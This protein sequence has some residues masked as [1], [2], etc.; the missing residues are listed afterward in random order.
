MRFAQLRLLLSRS[1]SRSY[2]PVIAV[3]AVISTSIVITLARLISKVVVSLVQHSGDVKKEI[4]CIC[5]IWLFRAFFQAQYEYF[6]SVQALKIKAQI[7]SQVT[8]ALPTFG[9]TSPAALTNLLVKGFNSLDIY[10]G[11]FFPQI[12]SALITPLAVIAVIA[13][14]DPTSALIAIITLPL[15]PFFG[16]LIG[17]YT[18]DSV[19]KKWATLGTLSKYFED[20][21]RGFVTL[22]IFGRHKSQAK[23]IREMGDQYTKETMQVLRISFL[24]AFALELCATLSVALIAVAIGL[25]LVNGDISFLSGLTVLLLAPEVYFPLR[26]AAALFHASADG[27]AALDE[28]GKL[29][30]RASRQVMQEANDFSTFEEISWSEWTIDI[31]TVAKSILPA[32]KVKRGEVLFITGESG[33]GKSTFAR[34]LLGLTEDQI[35]ELDSQI[36]ITPAS[37]QAWRKV[38]GWIPQTPHLA[39]GSIADQFRNLIPQI[40]DFEIAEKLRQ[41]G[42]DLIELPLGLQTQVGGFGEK[43]AAISGG[44]LRKIAI[45]RAIAV[46]PA[47]IIA[48]EPS[49]DLD[50]ASTRVIMKEFRRIVREGAALICITHETAM[51]HSDD[52]VISFSQESVNA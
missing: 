16:A 39:P 9:A 36:R 41:V 26:N 25:R 33:I 46:N 20:S 52:R 35:V 3:A 8:S 7:R 22:R 49:A 4:F 48:D 42:L 18:S 10:L 28:I 1:G 13:L 17:K 32:A 30:D 37:A 47:L 40:S 44:Q 51:I 27:K 2:F 11:R 12:V 19:A 6:T 29:F 38:V 45:A 21:L 5:L 24:S 50:E 15:I 31:P 34:N 43:S 14:F 23:R